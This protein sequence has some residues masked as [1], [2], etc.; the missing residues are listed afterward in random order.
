MNIPSFSSLS[1]TPLKTKLNPKRL[2]QSLQSHLN[3]SASDTVRFSGNNNFRISAALVAAGLMVGACGSDEAKVTDAKEALSTCIDGTESVIDNAHADCDPYNLLYETLLSDDDAL[4][5]Y[6]IDELMQLD[7]HYITQDQKIEIAFW[8]LT[9]ARQSNAI[10]DAGIRAM[11]TLLETET[12]PDE[13]SDLFNEVIDNKPYTEQHSSQRWRKGRW[14]KES[15]TTTEYT[16]ECG[17]SYDGNYDCEFR[18]KPVTRY[19]DVW[20]KGKIITQSWETR[21]YPERLQHILDQLYDAI[22]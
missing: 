9:G 19:R 21:E 8:A 7:D 1:A 3:S 17:L 2:Q 11:Q 20:E 13:V 12:L 5:S 14:E 16:N 6:A 15:Y 10:E 22:L 18:L 4:V